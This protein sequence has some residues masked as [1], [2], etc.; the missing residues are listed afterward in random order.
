MSHNKSQYIT[1]CDNQ[2]LCINISI[3]YRFIQQNH[4]LTKALQPEMFKFLK[5]CY[6]F[7][8]SRD[9]IRMYFISCNHFTMKP[10]SSLTSTPTYVH[11]TTVNL[12]QKVVTVTCRCFSFLLVSLMYQYFIRRLPEVATL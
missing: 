4:K 2:Q 8:Y 1:C 10:N 7:F 9:F 3:R 11:R 12:T 5:H 6:D